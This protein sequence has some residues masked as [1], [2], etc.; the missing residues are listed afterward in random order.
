MNL[1]SYRS[2]NGE[3]IN[4]LEDRTHELN[5]AH[6]WP[7]DSHGEPFGRVPLDSCYDT[8]PTFTDSQVRAIC[9]EPTPCDGR[10]PS[11]R[12]CLASAVTTIETKSG[13]Q[14]V[15]ELHRRLV[16]ERR[17]EGRP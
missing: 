11:G 13:P 4:L 9:A 15:C 1:T 8:A 3:R 7:R 6:T 16:A 14:P 17:G 10:F 5:S 12:S 2:P